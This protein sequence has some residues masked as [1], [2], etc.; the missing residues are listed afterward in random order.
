MTDSRTEEEGNYE[1]LKKE[2][3][4]DEELSHSENVA[5]VEAVMFVISSWKSTNPYFAPDS[6]YFKCDDCDYVSNKKISLKVHM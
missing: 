5:K 6:H 3:D 4:D 1:Y 2:L